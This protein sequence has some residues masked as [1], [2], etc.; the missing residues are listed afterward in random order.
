MRSCSAVLNFEANCLRLVK[1]KGKILEAAEKESAGK[2]K[3]FRYGSHP[4]LE[5]A[6]NMWLSATVTKQIPV[7]VIS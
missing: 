1:N 2:Q 5:E 7:S 3:N 4:K 6:L